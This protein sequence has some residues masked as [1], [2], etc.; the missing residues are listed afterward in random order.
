MTTLKP[1]KYRPRLLDSHID[2]LLGIFGAVQID[3]P[4]FCGKTWAAQ[5]H[6]SSQIRLD[7]FENYAL[8]L[9]DANTA[10]KGDAPRLV[11]EWQ[12]MPS[13]RD[14]IRQIVDESG[15]TPGL[16]ILTGS[17]VPPRGSYFHSG[18]GR[19]ARIHMRPMSLFEM[20]YSSGLVSLNDLFEGKQTE[21]FQVDTPI[22]ILASYLCRG[23]WPAA[24]DRSLNAAQT[25]A[26]QYLE[27]VFED[28]APRLGKTPSIARRAFASLSRNIATAATLDTIASDM[29]FGERD[30]AISKPAR[31]TVESYLDFYRDI[32][33]LEELYGWD[34]PVRSKKRLRSKPKRYL[35]D[36]SLAFAMLG[37]NERSLLNDMQT[38][39]VLFE[40][41]CLRDLRVYASSSSNL[42]GA[43]FGYYRDDSG[44]EVDVVIQLCDGRWG[45]IEVKLSENKVAD[46][47]KNLIA[48]KKRVAASVLADIRPP[49]FL[50]VLVGR[51]S[52]ARTTEE[53]V[54]IVPITSL[55]A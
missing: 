42:D 54:Q 45:G 24:L 7:S 17:S 51:T 35:T 48:L 26:R 12:E 21:A 6:A 10:L 37:M 31:A 52:F 13:I 3:G 8:A 50:V 11:D 41:M 36:P 32:Y 28:S 46:G 25:I 23:G 22:D 43:Q 55:T 5:A 14:N 34:A 29:F 38:F 39:G 53:G 40:N 4:K 33:L 20:G 27:S 2:T 47:V 18:A 49:S 19:I 15:S 1:V 30:E 44:L 16:F 9:A